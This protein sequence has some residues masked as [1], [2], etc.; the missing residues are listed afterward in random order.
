MYERY[1]GTLPRHDRL[2]EI[3]RGQVFPDV[4]D[5]VFHVQAISPRHLVYRYAEERTREAVVGK[6]FRLDEPDGEKLHRIKGE[7]QNLVTLRQMGFAHQP[8][9]VVRPLGRDEGIGLAV[10][11]ENVR[12]RDLDHFLRRAASGEDDGGLRRALEGLAVFLGALHRGTAAG[13]GADLGHVAWYAEKVLEKLVRQAVLDRGEAA[14]LYRL[15]DRWLGR[16]RMQA[17]AALVHGDATPTNFLFGEDGDVVAIDLERMRHADPAWDLGMVCGELKHAFLWRTGEGWAA[18]PFI[19]GFLGHYCRQFPDAED[20]FRRVTRRLPF[21][22]A[23]TEL[24]IARNGWLS[25]G[26]RRR[27]AGEAR[28]CLTWGLR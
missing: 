22:M 25:W 14:G 11:E 5:P 27:L 19:G 24:R 12:G 16:S 26:C 28:E 4:R 15:R 6:F 3:L 8:H 10:M 9:R 13:R 2:H 23:L 17:E 7:Y 21:Y 18:E 1:L 20:R